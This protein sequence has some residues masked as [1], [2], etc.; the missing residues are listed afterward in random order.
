MD[1]LLAHPW[2][3]GKIPTKEEM[4]IEMSKINA[5][6]SDLRGGGGAARVT[7]RAARPQPPPA[8]PRRQRGAHSCPS[9]ADRAGPRGD[10]T[11]DSVC[12]DGGAGG[13][14]F[15]LRRVEGTFCD[16]LTSSGNR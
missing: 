16:V 3:K 5:L 11:R 7:R 10:T 1:E 8:Q 14:A 12:G 2:M 13:A 9:G 15:T 4:H 6:L